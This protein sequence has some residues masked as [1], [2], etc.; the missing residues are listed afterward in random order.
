MSQN[1]NEDTSTSHF[2]NSFRFVYQARR[3]ILLMHRT[4]PLSVTSLV[5]K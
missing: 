2:P 3:N 1:E 4:F 5:E